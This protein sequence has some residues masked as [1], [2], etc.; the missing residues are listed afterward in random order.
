MSTSV[1]L[2]R[3]LNRTGG[4]EISRKRT[5]DVA[6]D[7]ISFHC[8]NAASKNKQDKTASSHHD[9]DQ[10]DEDKFLMDQDLGLILNDSNNQLA[11]RK[12]T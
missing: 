9:D 1:V 6:A 7:L 4:S 11:K 12:R 10:E 3:S 8:F 5:S 2:D